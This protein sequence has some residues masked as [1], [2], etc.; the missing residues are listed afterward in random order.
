MSMALLRGRAT[1]P[2]TASSWP[3]GGSNRGAGRG[4]GKGREGGPISVAAPRSTSGLEV[5]GRRSLLAMA[6][7]AGSA[8]VKVAV[9][10]DG[11]LEPAESQLLLPVISGS[12]MV[13]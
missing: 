6:T 4:E 3:A 13:A 7:R 1:A 5:T 9:H 11:I 2:P 8:P 10:S 12:G